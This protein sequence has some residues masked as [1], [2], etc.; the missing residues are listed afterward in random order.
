MLIEGELIQ[1]KNAFTLKAKSERIL[2][3]LSERSDQIDALIRELPGYIGP[4][5]PQ[6]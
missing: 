1:A 5:R 3:F 6:D 4:R 2:R